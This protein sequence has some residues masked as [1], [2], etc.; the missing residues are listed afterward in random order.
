MN[1]LEDI[2]KDEIA[3]ET[4]DEAAKEETKKE[5][6][7]KQK[8]KIE[9]LE[10]E[11]AV[12]KDKLLRNQAEL[13]NFK[14]RTNEERIKERKYANLGLVSDLISIVEN[15]DKCVNLEVSDPTLKNFLIGFQMINNQIFDLLHREGLED[16]K[17]LN[18][19][20]DPNIHH[21]VEQ[22]EVE[23]VESGVITEVMTKGYKFKDR[24]I[25]PA[26]V[27]VNK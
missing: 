1:E 3:Q 18:E 21:A 4:V 24:V 10:A 9:A 2:N 5:K 11:V 19:A 8:E 26:M 6:K 17:A 13:E 15:L 20:F 12:L 22:V 27:K 23:G 25:K 16:I 14:R 7:N